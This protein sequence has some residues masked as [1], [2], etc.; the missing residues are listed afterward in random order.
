MKRVEGV[1]IQ[2]KTCMIQDLDDDFYRDFQVIITGLD[3]VEARQWIN[4]TI[5]R[6]VE[7]KGDGTPDEETQIRLVDGG[8]EAFAGQARVI[9]PFTSGC[10]ECT[11]A[12]LPPQIAY[13]MCTVRETPRIPEHCIQY[14]YVIVW[15][16]FFGA[17]KADQVTPNPDAKKLDK[18]DPEHM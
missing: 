7:F 9:I 2:Y 3:N 13:P 1:N 17:V 4:A 10:Y 14:A 6:L 16:E 11:M 5:H 12:A 15:E 8:T 18:D